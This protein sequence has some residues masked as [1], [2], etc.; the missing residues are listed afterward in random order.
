MIERSE[1]LKRIQ[2]NIRES[3]YHVTLVA[4]ITVPRFAYTIGCKEVFG[5]E[6]IFAGGEIYSKN[7]VNDILDSV[8]KELSKGVEPKKLL[9]NLDGLGKFTLSEVHSSWAK[10][11]AL[12]AFDFYQADEINCWQI[13]PD[14][15]HR[16][17][18]IPDT[19]KEYDFASE[20]VWQWLV[21]KWDYPVPRESTAITDVKVLYGETA[22]D[23]M[24]WETNEWEIFS[25]P[26]Q[27]IEKKDTRAVPLA[28]L[29]GI[30][31]T[32]EP[33]LYLDVEKGLLRDAS[34]LIWHNWGKQS[35]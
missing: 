24:R 11:I 22:T 25:A 23:V 26:A 8:V 6:L 10:L 21:R 3:G 28:I 27:D 29:I 34:D 15:D 7:N 4:G 2:A 30:D 31:K 9:V 14:A 18:D 1:L 20:P 19:S 33:A 32:L 35:N 5:F 13:L 16:T 17:L 12:G